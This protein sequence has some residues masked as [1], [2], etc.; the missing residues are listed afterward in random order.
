MRNIEA[1][2]VFEYPQE[3]L[4]FAQLDIGHENLSSRSVVFREDYDELDFYLGAYLEINTGEKL[5]L[6]A[7]HKHPNFVGKIGVIVSPN[8]PNPLDLLYRFLEQLS[9][10]RSAIKWVLPEL[11]KDSWNLRRIDAERGEVVIGRFWSLSTAQSGLRFYE[12]R[13]GDCW[14]EEVAAIQ[15]S[16]QY[17]PPK[18]DRTGG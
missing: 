13:H 5:M 10:P 15:A 3:P 2:K 9:E 16:E 1:E 8:I 6:M 7:R 17:V 14:L 4:E 12:K 18:S 11:F